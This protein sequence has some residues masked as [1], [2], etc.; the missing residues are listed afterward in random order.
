MILRDYQQAAIDALRGALNDGVARPL[1]CMPTGSGKSPTI[2]TFV[3]QVHLKNPQAKIVIAVHTQELVEQLSKTYAAISGTVPA[4]FSASLNKRAIGP[5][6]FC[7]I[8][9]IA[10]RACD[11]GAI[12]LL[13]IDECDRSPLEGV[14]QYRTFIKEASVVNPDIRIAGFTAT[15]YRMGSGL[16]YGQDQPFSDM[17]YDVGIK[18]LVH[19]GFL[20]QLISKDGGAPDLTGVHVR[21]GDFVA[22]EL[23]AIMSEEETVHKACEE[24]LR[25]GADRKAWL[26]FA[27]GLKHATLISDKLASLGVEAPV[28]E[29]SMEKSERVRL[30]AAYRNRELRC[31]VNIN[32]LSIGFDAPHV[33]L[34][35]L[36]RPTKSAGLY[37]QQIGRGLRIAPGKANC[38]VLDLAGN[39]A[40]HGPIDTLNER[41]KNKK[42]S[43]KE[44]EAPTKTCPKCQEIVAAG[45]R[46]C[47]QCEFQFPP[48]EIVKHATVASYDSPL[49]GSDIRDVPVDAMN[50]RVHRP[51]DANKPPMLAVSYRCG[52]NVVTE[53]LSIDQKSHSYA[54]QMSRKWLRETP[55]TE[56]Q[57]KRIELKGD[58]IVGITTDGEVPLDTAMACVPFLCCIPKPTRIRYQ[59]PADGVKYPKV[60]GRSFA[61]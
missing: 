9:S 24:L 31:L 12:K 60:L 27:S 16:V 14:G 15:P 32:V 10:K 61:Q 38:L 5:V 50:V 19:E 8:Q 36:M 47:P 41:I 51:K 35:A 26:V 37:Y 56:A 18:Q 53:W 30:V 34:L 59:T 29:G 58:Q 17:V 3:H 52:I 42:K 39:I 23:E 48:P 22:S 7:Q 55:T 21:Q 45:V 6:T 20:S 44:G 54:R 4:V 2:A 40:R 57:G 33:D 13:V 49:S 46:E 28:V 43:K 1:V 25:Y 11:F